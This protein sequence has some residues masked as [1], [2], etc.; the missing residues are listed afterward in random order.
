[1]DLPSTLGAPRHC[2]IGDNVYWV[3][4]MT[5]LG[6]AVVM[7]WLDDV[8]PGRADRKMPPRIGDAASQAALCSFPGQVMLTWLALKDHGFSY[9]QAAE[10]V[11]NYK[12]A[13]EA[14]I[15]VKEKLVIEH[16]RLMEVFMGRRRTMKKGEGGE[17]WSESWLDES[18]AR[19]AGEYGLEALGN[20]TLDQYEWLCSSGKADEFG[21]FD[22][23]ARLAEW[24]AN[25]LPKILAAQ[26]TGTIAEVSEPVRPT[27]SNADALN[28]IQAETLS[29]INT[30]EAMAYKRAMEAGI[31]Q[32][33]PPSTQ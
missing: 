31:V 26:A 3:R 21:Q 23:E 25:E 18:Y 13:E 14:G 27:A 12:R 2:Y 17:D 1:M 15:E 8:L 29:A 20:L 24:R 33:L 9:A 5:V 28:V 16:F 11:P 7:N 22:I 10:L 32:E 6:M 30:A 19:L 4:P